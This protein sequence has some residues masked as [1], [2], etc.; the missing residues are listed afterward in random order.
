MT[1]V[2]RTLSVLAAC[3]LG[4]SSMGAEAS[5]LRTTERPIQGQYIVVHKDEAAALGGEMNI[6]NRPSIASVAQGMARSHGAQ[7]RRHFSH[8]LRGFVVQANDR[9]LER[10]LLDDRVAYVE[11]DGIVEL[12]ATQ[13][14]AT[15]GLD[16]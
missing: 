8:A 6:A 3:A 1:P 5:E 15:W 14:N 16:R 9:A 13:S 11:E 7:M 4:V 12:S 10:L 2:R